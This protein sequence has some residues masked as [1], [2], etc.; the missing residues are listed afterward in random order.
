MSSELSPPRDAS[1]RGAWPLALALL[2]I[3]FNLRPL[4]GSLSVVLPEVMRST[5]LSTVGA[6]VL[7]T[8][9]LACLGIFAWPAPVLA[10]RM[11][12][13]RAILWAMLLVCAGTLLRGVASLPVLF[14]ATA[15]AGSGI[16]VAN[17]LL[18]ALI[19]RDFSGKAGMMMG[20]YTVSVCAGAAGSAAFTVPIEHALD[21]SWSAALGFWGVPAAA[22]FLLWVPFARR[23]PSCPGERPR[24]RASLRRSALAWQVT[25]FMGLQ[26]SLAYIVMGWLA[27]MLQERGLS[28]ANAGFVVAVSIFMQLASCLVTPSIASRCKDQRLLAVVITAAILAAMLALLLA[29]LGGVW[30]WA[31]LLG[32]GQGASF[33]LA[34]TFFVLRAPDATVTSQLSAMAQGSGYLIASVGPLAAGL[35]RGWTGGFQ[36][37]AVLM[38]MIAAGMACSGWGAGR[39]LHVSPSMDPANHLDRRPVDVRS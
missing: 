1:E 20:L 33:A 6:S 19:K 21:G 5:A 4:F 36:A 10:R 15:V 30:W 27:P 13:E 23:K 7:T 18:P 31:V 35:L 22:A 38:A 37:S 39:A 24:A 28:S 12:P 8:V 3:G 2:L 17:V 26:S 34:L 9:P 11:G 29:P 32:V 25:A 14:V 16:A